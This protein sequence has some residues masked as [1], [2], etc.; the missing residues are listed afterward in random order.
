MEHTNCKYR[1]RFKHLGTVI[2]WN[3]SVVHITRG[4][5]EEVKHVRFAV[6]TDR[7]YIRRKGSS[8]FTEEGFE[9]ADLYLSAHQAI[10]SARRQNGEVIKVEISEVE[11]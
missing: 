2:C 9:K 7:G 10:L 11:Q 4:G 3:G 6:K 1:Y 8:H 5:V